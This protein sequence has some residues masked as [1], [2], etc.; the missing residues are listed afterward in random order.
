MEKLVPG[1]G[2]TAERVGSG[3]ERVR[4]TARIDHR[5]ARERGQH[6]N[7]VGF[8]ELFDGVQIVAVERRLIEPTQ[9]QK[10]NLVA[11]NDRHFADSVVGDFQ[12]AAA[13]FD[14]DVVAQEF[15]EAFR[16][17]I[18]CL[19]RRG[20]ISRFAIELKGRFEAFAIPWTD[21]TDRLFA[22]TRMTASNR[23]GET[24]G[25]AFGFPALVLSFVIALTAHRTLPATIAGLR[26]VEGKF[27]R[28]RSGRQ[29]HKFHGS[30]F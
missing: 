1:M 20:L 17:Q 30:N 11:R 15:A 4:H 14:P 2:E 26:H 9:P 6:V 18:E 23:S 25:D 3:F 27:A 22:S 10:R 13:T 12:R 21:R 29:T 5:P 24:C 7:I 28:L 16:R 8:E 19:G